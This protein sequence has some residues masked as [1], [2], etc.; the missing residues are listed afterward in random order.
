M[1]APAHRF[2]ACRCSH[3]ETFLAGTQ[4]MNSI[5]G[6]QGFGRFGFVPNMQDG[7]AP[8]ASMTIASIYLTFCKNG[9]CALLRPIIDCLSLNWS[10]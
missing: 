3:D 10:K 5:E 9:W 8:M 4:D 7:M 2:Q 6:K 1:T